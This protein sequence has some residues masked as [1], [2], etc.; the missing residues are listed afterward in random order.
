MSCNV[1]PSGFEA[2]TGKGLGGG[3]CRRKRFE[4]RLGLFVAAEEVE[5]RVLVGTGAGKKDDFPTPPTP[6][7]YTTPRL[8]I[9]R[10]TY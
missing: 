2:S 5:V 10:T 7:H 4:D 3:D 6:L 9:G 1:M 8:K